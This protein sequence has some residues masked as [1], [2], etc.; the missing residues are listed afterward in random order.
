MSPEKVIEYMRI[1]SSVT[2]DSYADEIA[3]LEKT[4]STL[5][6]SALGITVKQP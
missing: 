6:T 5:A 2:G 1:T 4:R 3:A